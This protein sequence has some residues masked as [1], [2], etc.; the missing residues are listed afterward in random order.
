MSLI[1]SVTTFTILW[2]FCF[3]LSFFIPILF[4][5]VVCLFSFVSSLGV[6]YGF[7]SVLFIAGGF[8]CRVY[9]FCHFVVFFFLRFSA[10]FLCL[11]DILRP[12]LWFAGDSFH[13]LEAHKVPPLGSCWI[14][15]E[16]WGIRGIVY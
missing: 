9:V 5:L 2:I 8:C 11:W 7:F 12:I 14:S 6:F 1:F 10:I 15:G 13:I 3:F 4:P 16:C